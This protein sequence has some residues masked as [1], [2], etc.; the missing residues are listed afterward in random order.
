MAFRH[1]S[2]EA[3]GCSFRKETRPNKSCKPLFIGVPVT[4]HL[5]HVGHFSI[6][7]LAV[8]LTPTQ[9]CQLHKFQYSAPNACR[10]ILGFA[11]KLSMCFRR[12][13]KV[14]GTFTCNVPGVYWRSELRAPCHSPP[15]G[16]HLQ[17]N[18]H[19]FKYGARHIR[20]C[21][22][23]LFF[24]STATCGIASNFPQSRYGRE[25]RTENNSPPLESGK[26]RRQ[27][28]HCTSIIHNWAGG[29]S[30]ILGL[31]AENSQATM[32]VSVSGPLLS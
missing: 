8:R 32:F 4:A 12:I 1:H 20:V 14:E 28:L 29:H 23:T 3:Y 10:Y 2:L 27:E 7:S 31:L 17:M 24:C 18:Q 26:R 16:P 9:K 5:P 11:V 21:G 19:A 30:W 6:C 13:E 22:S 15:S 25:G